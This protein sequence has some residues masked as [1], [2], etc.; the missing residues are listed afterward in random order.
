M[1][2]QPIRI[3]LLLNYVLLVSGI[4]LSVFAISNKAGSE[5]GLESAHAES[6]RV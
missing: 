3:G 5:Q 1:T 2:K 6:S 4:A